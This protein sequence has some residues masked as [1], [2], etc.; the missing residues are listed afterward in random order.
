MTLTSKPLAAILF[1]ILFGGIAFSTV[2]GWWQTESTKEAATYTE[3]EFAGQANPADIRGS[4]TFGDVEKNFQVPASLLAQAFAVNTTDPAAF[5]VKGL[6][7]MYAGSA[8][9]VGTASVRLFV[10]FYKGMPYDLS[11][12]IYLP[13]SAAAMLRVRNL[14]TE[15]AAYVAAHTVPNV[16]AQPVKSV[17][18]GTPQATLAP[19]TTSTPKAATPAST[20]TDRTIKG[21]TTF[22]DLLA[23]GVS[24]DAIEK[25]LGVSMPATPT[26]K[27]K[28]YCT[29]RGMDFEVIKTALQTL[30]DRA[31]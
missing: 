16:G 18:G 23:W 21:S 31:K 10:A 4:Y 11:T 2:M 27:V 6:E 13:E 30:V 19:A 7:E 15:Q 29:E 14:T 12:A 3:G 20:S 28:D 22:A 26:I 5:N 25:G 17:P 9:E 8:Q 1:V 24:K